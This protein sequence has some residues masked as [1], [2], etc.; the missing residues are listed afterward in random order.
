MA[1]DERVDHQHVLVTRARRRSDWISSPPAQDQQIGPGLLLQRGHGVGRL[2]AQQGGV[3]HAGA[4]PGRQATYFCCCSEGRGGG[5]GGRKGRGGEGGGG[6]TPTRMYEV[7]PYRS[8]DAG[9]GRCRRRGS[10]HGRGGRP[11]GGL[12]R[13]HRRPGYQAGRTA[14]HAAARPGVARVLHLGYADSGHGPVRYPD[15]PGEVR[16][17]RRT[18]TRPRAFWAP[19]PRRRR[20]PAINLCPTGPAQGT[21]RR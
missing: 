18:R 3:L 21:V 7:L 10:A 15:S 13:R 11:C 8:P 14:G 9:L 1:E 20:R 6:V 2:P 4:R 12:G 19:A 5:G 16:F 17:A